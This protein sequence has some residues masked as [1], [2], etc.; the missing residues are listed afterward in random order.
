MRTERAI[1]SRQMH[2]LACSFSSF[3]CVWNVS[4]AL[5]SDSSRCAA[6]KEDKTRLA[7]YDRAIQPAQTGADIFK[8]VDFIDLKVDMQEYT[9]QHISVTGRLSMFSD[10]LSISGLASGSSSIRVLYS[11]LPRDERKAVLSSCPAFNGCDATVHGII[12]KPSF[13]DEEIEASQ[14]FIRQ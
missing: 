14:I 13:G 8:E 5:S 4:T 12:V 3:L 1:R 10:Y 7:C 9:G 6:I 2:L 11:K